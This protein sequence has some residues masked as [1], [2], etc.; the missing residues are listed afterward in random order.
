MYEK[1]TISILIPCYNAGKTIQRLLD[2]ILNQTYTKYEVI[3]VNDASTDDVDVVIQ[4]YI[5]IFKNKSIN[6]IY[7][8]HKN[9]IGAAGAIN[10]GL[11][12]VHGEYLVWPD[13]DDYFTLNSLQTRIN[14]L[15]ANPDC[16]FCCGA[17]EMHY[18]DNRRKIISNMFEEDKVH[19]CLIQML[20]MKKLLICTGQYMIKMPWFDEIYPDREIF[21]TRFGQNLQ[22]LLPIAYKS[23]CAVVHDVVYHYMVSKN[24]N[25]LSN[26]ST[27]ERNIKRDE[28][29]EECLVNVIRKINSFG[30][31][32]ICDSTIKKICDCD[33]L[34]TYSRHGVDIS[35]E[36]KIMQLAYGLIN[37]DELKIN[38]NKRKILIWGYNSYGKLWKK[39]LENQGLGVE[40]FIDSNKEICDGKKIMYYTEID[41]DRKCYIF[42]SM[43][44]YYLDVIQY[45]H[46]MYYERVND[47]FYLYEEI[48]DIPAV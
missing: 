5:N 43:R 36:T 19:N 22:M 13:A 2:S 15:Q 16:G 14:S 44:R 33:R 42:V 45:L 21:V 20:F 23:N 35:D 7:L 47:Y 3:L 30:K 40:G 34:A 9:N 37:F 24:G 12:Y 18:V 29:Y 6:F 10:T 46:N 1:D 4:K 39:I 31:R 26:I 8:K 25:Y 41:A 48:A 27:L 17:V 28:L 38:V 11:K 32:E